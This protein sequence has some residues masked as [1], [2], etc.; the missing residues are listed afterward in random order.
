MEGGGEVVQFHHAAQW[1][2]QVG[3]LATMEGEQMSG[4]MGR[5]GRIAQEITPELLGCSGGGLYVWYGEGE[6]P[7]R[8]ASRVITYESGWIEIEM[9]QSK[10]TG[11]AYG[12][13]PILGTSGGS[14]LL[15]PGTFI[16]IQ[17]WKPTET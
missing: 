7:I 4:G 14:V 16:E 12:S 17:L 13:E 11:R 9:L 3:C 8:W 1:V 6:P 15:S 10:R 5:I 2:N